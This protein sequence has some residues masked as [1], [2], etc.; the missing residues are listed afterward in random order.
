[1]AVRVAEE[2]AQHPAAGPHRRPGQACPGA[3]G[4]E[5]AEDR[6]RQ[7]RQTGDA[8]LVQVGLG[9]GQVMPVAHDRFR[10]QA[11]LGGQVLEEPWHRAG[12]GDLGPSP[13]AA[14]RT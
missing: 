10:A 12:E 4:D 3:L 6:R 11:A 7:L 14:A 5:R 2:H 1:L 13:L 8:D 9:P